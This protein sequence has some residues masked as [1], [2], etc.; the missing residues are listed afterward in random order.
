MLQPGGDADLAKEA[1]GADPGGELG[2]QDL[3]G[4]RPIVAE[5][6]A[7]IDDRHAA[8]AEL[9]VEAI[10]ALEAGRESGDRIAQ[11]VIR[12]GTLYDTVRRYEELAGA[13]AA[14][15]SLAGFKTFMGEAIEHPAPG[16]STAVPTPVI[17]S[18]TA[19]SRS[20]FTHASGGTEAR[21]AR[22]PRQRS[23]RSPAGTPPS[24][25]ARPARRS[26]RASA[27]AIDE[28][29]RYGMRRAV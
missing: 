23:R 5:V 6:P 16:H 25:P 18:A 17:T 9:A 10:A 2:P 21:P 22:R 19:Q 20:R 1:V 11:R 4:D 3:D 15:W 28:A 26:T 8:P 29:S 7:A 12:W 27:S 24:G 13:T 14:R